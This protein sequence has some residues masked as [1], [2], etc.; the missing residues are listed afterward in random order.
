MNSNTKSDIR[1]NIIN[2]T[3]ILTL[4]MCYTLKF[5]VPAF[6]AATDKYAGLFVFLCEGLLLINNYN[7]FDAIKR[8]DKEFI[9]ITLL[10]IIIGVNLIIVKSGFGAYFT[11]AN[12]ALIFYT[13]NKIILN[14]KQVTIISGIYLVMLLFWLVV[15]YPSYFGSYDASFALNT[16]GAA[17]F[18]TYTALIALVF[19]QIYF[20][21]Y[22]WVELP[23]ILLFVRT[24]RLAL[25]HRARG[26]FIILTCFIFLFYVIKG[27]FIKSKKLY[28]TLILLCTLGSLVFVTFY[29]L[30]GKTGFNMFLPIFYKNI[31]S[32]RENIWYEFFTYFIHK[33]L[34]GI[35]TNLTIES[36]FEFNVHNAMYDILVVH[37]IIV[38]VLTM[39]FVIKRFSFFREKA[40]NNKI[41]LMALCILIS[42]FFESFIDVDL[43]W[44]DYSINLIFLLA[45][46]NAKYDNKVSN[47]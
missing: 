37:G 3:V 17:T 29:T 30:L 41:V 22:K 46:I 42:V 1:K 11:A 2:I 23:I 14:K 13:S 20:E 19:L 26:A 5:L 45:V 7:V 31:F 35:G 15:M 28:T 8:R 9:I 4:F 39:Y 6:Y 21:K 32:G 38:F 10:L 43:I 18:S 12:F 34:T 25:W 27:G 24:I 47:D 16:N 44:A 36:F 33:P 40:L